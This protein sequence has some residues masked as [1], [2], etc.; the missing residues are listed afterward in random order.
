[1]KEQTVGNRKLRG[2]SSSNVQSTAALS[3]MNWRHGSWTRSKWR[4]K[5][6]SSESRLMLIWGKIPIDKFDH[7]A[8]GDEK[9]GIVKK[10]PHFPTS[11]KDERMIRNNLQRR[12]YGQQNKM[13]LPAMAGVRKGQNRLFEREYVERMEVLDTDSYKL[14]L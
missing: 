9:S 1:V 7:V 4:K 6:G 11:Q 2:G 12:P 8:G 3:G 5:E 10:G 13:G 14:F